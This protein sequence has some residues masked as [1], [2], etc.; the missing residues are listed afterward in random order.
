[1]TMFGGKP[2]DESAAL[3]DMGTIQVL[4][5]I[6]LALGI[7]GSVYAARRIAHSS[8]RTATKRRVAIVP[9][10]KLVILLGAINVWMFALPMAHRR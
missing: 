9:V 4:Q 7:A 8:R 10:M 2:T 5:Y 6:V 3:L 1:M